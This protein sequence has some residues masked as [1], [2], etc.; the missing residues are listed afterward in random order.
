MREICYHATRGRTT[1][2]MIWAF[3]PFAVC[4]GLPVFFALADA[5]GAQFLLKLVYDY[6]PLVFMVPMLHAYISLEKAY[7]SLY[8][9]VV[10]ITDDYLM[11]NFDRA[12]WPWTDIE[13]LRITDL[14]I[15]VYVRRE[16]WI[17]KEKSESLSYVPNRKELEEVLVKQ[18]EKAGI[19]YE[20]KHYH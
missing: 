12:V 10:R 6:F 2:I 5:P 18:C 16:K 11:M 17:A 4:I 8:H 1:S 13:K 15:H 19:P 7:A 14:S 9:P 3:L 20:V